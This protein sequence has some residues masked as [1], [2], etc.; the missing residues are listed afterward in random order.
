MAPDLSPGA[1]LLIQAHD[2]SASQTDCGNV[3][4]RRKCGQPG[5]G[6]SGGRRPSHIEGEGFLVSGFD[7]Q[8]G[9]D[10]L[11]LD[12]CRFTAEY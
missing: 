3:V 9:G 4:G 1:V 10:A 12:E 11:T 7:L 2:P 6:R 8:T 5:S